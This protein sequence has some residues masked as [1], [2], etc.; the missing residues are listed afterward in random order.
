MEEIKKKKCPLR[1]IPA[2][3]KISLFSSGKHSGNP[4]SGIS[5][6]CKTTALRV[7]SARI[8]NL[9]FMWFI[10]PFNPFLFCM[11]MRSST[12][13]NPRAFLILWSTNPFKFA[14]SKPA[15]DF[16]RD[17]ADK[18]VVGCKFEKPQR[19]HFDKFG[20]AP[21]LYFAVFNRRKIHFST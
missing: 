20:A 18:R 17:F 2:G 6:S 8:K 1:R 21:H 12:F 4:L 9:L 14:I 13:H 11:G 10:S 19:P 16:L 7:Y 15:P 3:E 5:G